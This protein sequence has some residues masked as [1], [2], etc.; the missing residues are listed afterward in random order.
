MI[1]NKSMKNKLI[2]SKPCPASW[3]DMTGDAKKKLCMT[4]SVHVH[5]LEKLSK[6]E[7]NVLIEKHK[8]GDEICVRSPRA[9]GYRYLAFIF[10]FIPFLSSCTKKWDDDQ[11]LGKPVVHPGDYSEMFEEDHKKSERPKK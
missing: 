4:C 6:K 3:S 1:Y 10:A 11:I 5:D 2:V 9:F 7:I 8:A